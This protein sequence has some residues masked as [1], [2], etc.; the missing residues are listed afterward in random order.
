MTWV[1]EQIG[2]VLGALDGLGLNQST[3]VM[4][5]AD[6]GWALGEQAMFCKMANFELQT[7][8][9]LMI[10]A[11]WLQAA[12]SRSDAMVELVDM[13][14]TALE[15]AGLGPDA[16]AEEALEGTSLAPLVA[17]PGLHRRRPDLWKNA[18]FS[19]YPRCMNST[20][21]KTPPFLAAEDPCVG[22]TANQITHMGYSMRTAEWRYAEWPKWVCYGLDGD[23]DR[24]SDLGK[25]MG[26]WSG[27]ANWDELGGVELYDH[28][29]DTGDCF[30][31]YENENLANRPE[32]RELVKRLSAQLR[33][34]WRKAE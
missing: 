10:R 22:H 17:E 13:L 31:C 32:N 30:D 25:T 19:Q 16:A 6:H 28:R 34:G 21:A 5:W 18:A 2:K 12:G 15:L 20:M 23:P 26:S 1:D 29:G 24:C 3:L 27:S 14:P 8:V 4:H 11:P 33:A 9:P 7:R